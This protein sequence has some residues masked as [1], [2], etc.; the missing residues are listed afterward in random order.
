M[1]LKFLKPIEKW[2]KYSSVRT[3][4]AVYIIYAT[5]FFISNRTATIG[6]WTWI[7][8]ATLLIFVGIKLT[9]YLYQK[10]L[11]NINRKA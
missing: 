9:N 4:I 10:D 6:L 11:E 1:K 7:I 5:V 8:S 3:K 2:I